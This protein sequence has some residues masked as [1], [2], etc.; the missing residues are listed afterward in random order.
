MY[1]FSEEHL[2]EK[3]S[4]YRNAALEFKNLNYLLHSTKNEGPLKVPFMMMFEYK[5]FLGM[6]RTKLPDSGKFKNRELFES[7]DQRDLEENSRISSEVL[8]NEGKCKIISYDK[9]TSLSKIPSLSP[10]VYFV[11]RLTEYLPV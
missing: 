11:E 7:F 3:H 8:L 9:Q 1:F 2:E 4:R 5:G 10:K 6:A